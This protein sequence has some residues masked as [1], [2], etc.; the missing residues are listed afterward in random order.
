MNKD[1]IIKA[2]DLVN[3]DTKI[4]KFYFIPGLISVMF[5]MVILVYQVIYTY[6]EL[7]NQKDKALSIILNIFHS[8]YFTEILIIGGIFLL[9]YIIIIP[10]F[11]G[12]LIWYISKKDTLETKVS[13]TDS[14]SNGVYRFLPLFEYGNIFSQFK[15]LSM[16]NIYLFCLRFL[17]IQYIM[18]LNYVFIF[19]LIISTI[20]NILFVYCRFEIV[21]NNKKALES[22]SGSAKISI[23][24][25]ATTARIYFF[26]FLVN[27]R[28]ILNFIVF[29]FFPIVIASAITYIST[30]VYLFITVCILSIIFMVFIVILGYLG[31]VFEVLKTSVRYNAYIEGKK[32]LDEIEKE[33]K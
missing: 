16:V 31:G 24:N 12:S 4:K 29:L 28:V 13:I 25:I 1:I 22:L 14:I 11:E 3:H 27:I 26:L 20:I 5:L 15:F 18:L 33:D 9:F 17:G 2:W 30:K 23:L 10:I 7:F 32:K 21:L 19:L 6:V 8:G